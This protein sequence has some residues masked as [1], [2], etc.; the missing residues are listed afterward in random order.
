MNKYNLS[1]KS[2]CDDA[3]EA[4]MKRS[5]PLVLAIAILIFVN[6]ASAANTYEDLRGRFVIDLP[7][8]WQLQPQTE[9]TVYV[10]K[11]DNDSIIL[12]YVLSTND[13]DQLLKKAL[14]TLNLSGLR[15]ASPEGEVKS[16]TVNG[17]PARWGV[18]KSE[19]NVGSIK[20]TLFGLVGS[21]S[22]KERGVY[23]LSIMNQNKKAVLDEPLKKAFQSIRN[24]GQAVTGVSDV[25]AVSA[26]T[27]AGSPTPWEHES[28]K[29]ILPPGWKEKPKLQSFEKEVIGWFEYEPLGGTMLAVCY[30]GF[31]MDTSKALKAAKQTVEA[32]IPNANPTKA[33]ELKLDNGQK[34]PVIVYQGTSVSRGTEVRM[35]AVTATVETKKCY[36]DLIGFVHA[37]GTDELERN[38]V[39][40]IRSA[41]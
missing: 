19:M 6:I 32:S 17:N 29:I 38:I 37:T 16:L 4:I 20:V 21:V 15:N 10:F 27:G 24:P 41:R 35:G 23:F 22:L 18:Y 25:K 36:L 30:R 5:A 39:E 2:T 34:T 1:T 13:P 26:K 12:E 31:G 33:Y 14:V 9:D 8:G 11:R 40:I 28:V 3:K 7:E